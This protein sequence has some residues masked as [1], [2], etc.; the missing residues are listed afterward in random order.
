MF[1][2]SLYNEAFFPWFRYKEVSA[3]RQNIDKQIECSPGASI[4]IGKFDVVFANTFFKWR[5]ARQSGRWR[6]ASPALCLK[7]SG[8]TRGNS[9]LL[10]TGAE[11]MH[12][13]SLAYCTAHL[14]TLHNRHNFV[15]C[16]C[17]CRGP[18]AALV[19]SLSLSVEWQAYTA[20]ETIILN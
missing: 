12:K 10:T 6:G 20:V 4:K 19:F 15:F 7:W 1:L 13:K 8:V 5:D 9:R 3:L 17:L 16:G 11:S 18:T 14:G 2:L